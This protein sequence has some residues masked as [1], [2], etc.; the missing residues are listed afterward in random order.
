MGTVE[1]VV[2]GSRGGKLVCFGFAETQQFSTA[3]G[4]VRRRRI[5]HK[6]TVPILVSAWQLDTPWGQPKPVGEQRASRR[7]SH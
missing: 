6:S 4:P 7:L 2:K 1:L 3:S 5:V